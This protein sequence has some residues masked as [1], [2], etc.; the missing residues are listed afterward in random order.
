MATKVVE[1]LNLEEK[2]TVKNIANWTVGFR[3]KT[4]ME[5]DISIAPNGQVR[6]SRN[7]IIAQVQTDNKLFSGTDG[8]GSHA[9]LLIDDEATRKELDFDSEDGKS[10]QLVF[11]DELVKNVFAIKSQSAFENTFRETFFTRAEKYAVIQA[12]KRLKINDYSRIRFAE[13]YTEYS[14]D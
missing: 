7:E 13:K 3:R 2:V 9:T 4:E 8:R 10:K 1:E 14:V 5:G 12:I 6:L 11:S